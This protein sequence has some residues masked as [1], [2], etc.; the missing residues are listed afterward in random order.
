MDSRTVRS[1][2]HLRRV[3]LLLALLACGFQAAPHTFAQDIR[4]FGETGHYL[5]GAFRQFYERNGGVATFGFPIT[6]EY[7][8]NADGRIVQWFQRARFEL[9][10]ANPPRVEL[11]RLGVEA[12]GGKT[13]PGVPPFASS[14]RVRYFPETGHSLR[15]L[16]K[17]TW[18]RR[19]V[20]V[21][22]FPISE[23][24]NEQI[25]GTWTLVQYF[26][27]ARFELRLSPSRVTFGLLGQDLAPRQLLD[28]WPPNYAPPGPLNEDGTPRPPSGYRPGAGIANLRVTPG[29]GAR[30][31][32][33][34]IEGE[35]F[36]PGERVVFL[37]TAPDGRV[38]Q[39]DGL[40]LAD[41]NGSI[42]YASVRINSK[43]LSDGVWSLS[44][45]GISSGRFGITRFTV[46]NVP[47]PPPGQGGGG[48]PS[49]AG[50]RVAPNIVFIGQTFT[51]Q[52]EG[53]D[54]GE[55]V[56]LWLTAPDQSVRGIDAAPDADRDGSIS[57]SQVRVS[58]DIGFR[59]GTWFITAQGRSSQR[60]AI[61]QFRID[62]PGPT[63]GG[64]GD[65]ARLGVVLHER[66]R[67]PANG[68]VTPLAAPPGFSFVINA[69][70]FDGNEDIS[71][72]AT[73][74]GAAA[75]GVPGAQV[76]RDGRGNVRV[77]FRPP[78]GAE[79]DWLITAE[80]RSSRRT[81]TAPFRVTRDFVAPLGTARPA[82]SPNASVTPST[83][84]RGTSFR[85]SA[86]GFRANETLEFWITSPDGIY[87]LASQ[88]RADAS[89]R[90]GFNPSLNVTLADAN[91]AGIYG[92]HYRGVNS[93][94][95]A[96]IYFTYTGTA[97]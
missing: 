29:G 19:G 45:N 5:R 47:Q 11:G 86:T 31:T 79:G 25:G 39:T 57:G 61:G 23:E 3:V 90:I 89:G 8:R 21:Y 28:A 20:G 70:G 36:Q 65:P 87:L 94:A 55:K 85:L 14:T 82:N 32:E 77:A 34:R 48:Q 95:R 88:V 91:P 67:A 13:F 43:D 2:M 6:E 27:R 81:V 52:G 38:V 40:P 60:T 16:F 83:G 35:G 41:V 42:T 49:G 93:L 72:Y 69:S 63:A 17:E 9:A 26:E 78:T 4:Y 92:Y 12:S 56:S 7:R 10:E 66:L 30:G 53:F 24:I 74:P 75:Q 73:P 33:F 80:G 22:G 58:V 68:S 15:G 18:E 62:V 84:A 54:R 71:V 44:A 64:A 59:P 46:G 51:V 97:R 96:D 76:T 37:L 1:A 50:V